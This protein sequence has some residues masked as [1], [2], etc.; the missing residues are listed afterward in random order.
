M[1]EVQENLDDDFL[2]DGAELPEEDSEQ[3]QEEEIESE[4]E[5]PAPRGY[6]T[7]DAWIASGKDPEKW[8]SPELFEERGE[9]IKMKAHYDSLLKNQSLL[10]QIQLKNQREEL[11]AKRDDAIDIADKDAVKRYDKQIKELDAMDELAKTAEVPAQS[12]KPPEIAEWEAE[13]PWCYTQDDARTKLANRIFSEAV[14][15]GKTTA[16][17]LRMVDREI[18]AKFSTKS[19]AP[20]QIAEGARSTG[21]QRSAES[22]TMKTLSRDEQAAWD[23]GLFDDEKAF[24]KVVS[25]ERKALKK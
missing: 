11:L 25:I 17:A 18:A 10:H 9:R 20:R 4:A 19:N 7:K 16:T 1:S 23:S 2:E 14:S 22:V 8:V 21:G 15:Q 13:N 12:G 24:L 6:M 5:K 3:E